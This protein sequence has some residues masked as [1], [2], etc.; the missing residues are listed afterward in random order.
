[1]SESV[2]VG[3]DCADR[4][5]RVVCA[6]GSHLEPLPLADDVREVGL[7]FDPGAN[8]SNLGVRFPSLLQG[9]GRNVSVRFSQRDETAEGLLTQGFFRIRQTVEAAAG[10]PGPCVVAVPA[11]LGP[12]RR[13]ALMDCA[14]A[15]GWETVSLIDQCTAA[16]LAHHGSR[17]EPMTTLVA[18]FGYGDCEFALVRLAKGHCG[19]LASGSVGGVSGELFEALVME[20]MVLALRKRHTFLGLTKW[21]DREWLEFRHVAED[22]RRL[23]GEEAEPVI[24]LP[25]QVARREP[26]FMI[27]FSRDP[28]ARRLE[29]L[30]ARVASG[31]R[32][33]LDQNQ[34]DLADVDGFLVIGSAPEAPV[35]NLLAA[36][37]VGK[38]RRTRP[39]LTAAGAAWQACLLANRAADLQ[40]RSW[41]ESG[42]DIEPAPASWSQPGDAGTEDFAEVLGKEPPASGVEAMTS[43]NEV[44]SLAAVRGL[45]TEG[46]YLEAEAALEAVLREA[47]GLKAEL[48]QHLSSSARRLLARAQSALQTGQINLAVMLSHQAHDEDR[49][50]PVVFE[51]MMKIHCDGGAMLSR[52]EQY[53]DAIKLLECAHRHDQSDRSIHKAMTER[54]YRHAL[55]MHQLNN[56]TKSLAAV[57][58]AL[59]YDHKHPGANQLLQQLTGG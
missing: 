17:E 50:D 58:Q 20:G 13:S 40:A 18:A 51:G 26:P 57:K 43:G 53:A 1:M 4:D 38:P 44:L 6:L 46:Q 37:F 33:A 31:V 48:A 7:F 14:R 24:A 8:I 41:E 28:F 55:A 36:A 22:V 11:V 47:E 35:E 9:L 23:L 2:P 29:P 27:R 32:E 34:L 21:T 15:A 3:I 49:T 59:N 45:L 30:V 54:H 19:V 5:W 52:P 42:Q 25:P 10:P 56:I 16:A 39:D 12:S